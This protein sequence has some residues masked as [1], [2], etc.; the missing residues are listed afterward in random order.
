MIGNNSYMAA[1]KEGAEGG[2]MNIYV[3]NLSLEVTDEDLKQAFRAFGKVITATVIKDR[4]TGKSRG[5]GFVDM[6]VKLEAQ[7]AI[8]GLNKKELKGRTLRINEARPRTGGPIGRWEG[9]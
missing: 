2:E 7:A 5:F 6:P 9:R 3:G 1:K 4:F 8:N